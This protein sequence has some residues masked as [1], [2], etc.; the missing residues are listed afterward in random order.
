[1]HSQVRLAVDAEGLA[2]KLVL[3]R[4]ALPGCD[5]EQL[6]RSNVRL[7]VAGSCDALQAHVQQVGAHRGPEGVRVKCSR[8]TSGHATGA[9]HVD[10]DKRLVPT[11]MYIPPSCAG[12]VLALLPQGRHR[13][14][15]AEAPGLLDAAALIETLTELQRL[16][17]ASS[18]SAAADMLVGNPSLATLT[19]S[20]ASQA[21]GDRDAEYVKD[22][23]RA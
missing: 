11:A 7:L 21:R 18:I 2:A 22:I 3:L 23:Y 8:G 1:M 10:A 14:V 6:A 20:L 9:K 17:G 15:L 12:Q 19:S 4:T 5:V 13:A 16:F